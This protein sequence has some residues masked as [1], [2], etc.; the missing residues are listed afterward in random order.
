MTAADGIVGL[1][2]VLLGSVLAALVTV[3]LSPLAPFGPVRSV[4]P[5]P[6]ASF[7]WTVLGLGVAVLVVSLGA[8]AFAFAYRW[9]PHRADLRR[10]GSPERESSVARAAAASGLPVSA[11]AG[12]RFALESRAGRETV[13]V[14]SA[15]LGTALALVVLMATITFGA[16][17]NTLVSN[18]R[19][20]GW[21]WDY[22]LGSGGN[23]PERQA[24]T[25]L[26]HDR[27]VAAWAGYYFGLLSVDGRTVPVLG[28][29]PGAAVQPPVLTGHGLEAP[30]QIVLGAVTLAEL[31]KHVGDTVAVSDG[32]RPSATLRIVGSATMPTLGVGGEHLEMGTG[33][34]L[35][36]QLIP[37]AQRNLFNN[38]LTGPDTIFVDVRPGANRTAA[39]RSLQQIAPRLTNTANFGVFVVPVA[40]PAEI[41]NYRSLGTTPALLGATLAAGA[42]VG[43]GLTLVASVRRRRRDIALL[44]TLG[45]TERQIA[46]TIAWQ[47]SVAVAVG[48]VVGLP[49][50]IVLGRVA[51]DL[52]AHE[53]HA[54]PAPSVPGVATVL[55]GIGAL[56]IANVV[57][58]VPGRIAARTPTALL[59]RA[60]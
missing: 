56:V 48:T 10:R 55:V 9:N 34:L 29:R 27:S 20:F 1:L 22:A 39:L 38:P 54:V 15:I 12:I 43:L 42:V 58:S 47:S 37:A 17:L 3:A 32:V 36:S 51:W 14:R 18:P 31:H 46:A 45:F 52:F 5:S 16:S 44:K 30:D 25:L 59:L 28:G 40:H 19:L 24:A 6:G 41:V 49:I 53:I 2:G 11:V 13:P 23:I 33:A 4:Y 57:A 26:G 50:G 7:D 60:E 21:N 35:S 8:L